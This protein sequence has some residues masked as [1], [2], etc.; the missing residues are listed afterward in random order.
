M[1]LTAVVVLLGIAAMMAIGRMA[2]ASL[3]NLGS[4][5]DARQLALDLIGAQRRAIATGDNHYLQFQVS[6][7]RLLGYTLYRAGASGDVAVDNF[8]PFV[9]GLTVQGSHTRAEF[10]F[11]GSALAAYRFTLAAPNRTW[12]VTVIPVTGAVRVIELF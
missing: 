4:H 5:T 1:E 3:T 11:E 12:Q 6:G 7:G 2:P 9:V 8:R 10:N